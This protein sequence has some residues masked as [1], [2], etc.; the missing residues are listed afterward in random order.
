[1]RITGYLGILPGRQV[2]GISL[3]IDYPLPGVEH[4]AVNRSNDGSLTVVPLLDIRIGAVVLERGLCKIVRLLAT[5]PVLCLIA[6][7]HCLD[8][9]GDVRL[10]PAD[11]GDAIEVVQHVGP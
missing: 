5:L 3:R 10:D 11:G 1:M 9:R 6:E 4:V 8:L 2:R 7:R